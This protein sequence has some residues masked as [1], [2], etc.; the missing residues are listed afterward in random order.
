MRG[1]RTAMKSGPC[2]L[3][4]EKALAQKRTPN[5]AKNKK[6]NLLKKKE[7]SASSSTSNLITIDGLKKKKNTRDN[8]HCQGCGEKGTLVHCWWECK[9]V[10]PL[11]K[12]VWRFLKKIKNRAT[13]DLA[14]PHLGIYLKEMKPPYPRDICTP[15]VIAASFTIAKTWEQRKCPLTDERIKKMW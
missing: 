10:Q 4:L 11:W 1:P 5:T 8:K 15:L 7:K 14:I 12:A 6:I 13:Y 9:L 3:Q 2:S